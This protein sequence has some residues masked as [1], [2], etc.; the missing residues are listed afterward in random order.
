MTPLPDFSAYGY[1]VTKQLNQN[2]Q[3]GRI[4]YKALKIANQEP[5]VIKQF[6][7]ATTS[8]WDSHKQIEREIEVLKGLNHPGIPRYFNQFYPSDGLCLVQEYKQ[9]QPLSKLRVLALKR[10]KVSLHNY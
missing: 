7:F 3:G 8:D 4:T 10:L 1:Q 5:V 2:I 9:A 6:R